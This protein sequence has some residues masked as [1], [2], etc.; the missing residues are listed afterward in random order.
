[1]A[2]MKHK[3]KEGNKHTVEF[4]KTVRTTQTFEREFVVNKIAEL[5]SNIEASTADKA[6]YDEILTLIDAK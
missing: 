4:E 6:K 5:Q 1:M 2:K 3:K